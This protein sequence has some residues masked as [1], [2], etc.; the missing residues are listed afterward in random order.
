MKKLLFILGLFISYLGNAQGVVKNYPNTSGSIDITPSALTT[1]GCL[2]AA[3]DTL[4]IPNGTFTC[5]GGDGLQ[6]TSSSYIVIKASANTIFHIVGFRFDNVL[7]NTKYIKFLGGTL[8]TC[9]NSQ[10]VAIQHGCRNLT[11]ESM[12]F[13]KHT[14]AQRLFQFYENTSSLNWNGNRNSVLDSMKFHKCTFNGEENGQFINA[15]NIDNA[16]PALNSICLDWEIDSCTFKNLISTGGAPSCIEAKGAWG[17]KI[18]DNIFDSL[19]FKAP[20]NTSIHL[21]FGSIYGDHNDI[22][23]NRFSH[24]RANAIRTF[25]ITFNALNYNSGTVANRA[26]KLYNNIRSTT[27]NYPMFEVNPNNQSS[28]ISGSAGVLTYGPTQIYFNTDYSSTK[29]IYTGRLVDL[30]NLIDSVTIAHNV[31]ILP[32]R[33]TTY[34]PSTNANYLITA[35]GRNAIDTFNNKVFPTLV[36]AGVVDTL[37]FL[38]L[39]SSLLTD[40]ATTTAPVVGFDIYNISRPQGSARDIGS[41]ERTN[42]SNVPPVANAGPNQTINLPTTTATLDGSG[43]TDP[44]GTITTYSWVKTSGPS[45]GTITTPS[46]AISTVTGMVV[47]TYVFTLTV[48]DNNSATN[49]ASTTII[50]NNPPTCVLNS[51]TDTLVVLNTT[52]VTLTSAGSTDSDGTIA[53]YAWSKLSGSGSAISTPTASST[54]ITGLTL[55]IFKYQLIITDNRGATCTSS[56]RI[57]V[58]PN[59]TFYFNERGTLVYDS[60][61]ILRVAYLVKVARNTKSQVL[62]YVNYNNETII[63]PT[64]IYTEFTKTNK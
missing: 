41:V 5:Y 42:A 61:G 46:A 21:Q 20:I 18:H 64:G 34:S 37:A 54:L 38:P 11:W 36:A 30:V 55:G 19:N 15:G 40:A 48:T 56:I 26:N 53:S 4:L 13:L 50:I 16:L 47:G 60:S 27:N 25:P 23:N 7:T 58:L 17:W 45:S 9:G 57:T 52:S 31:N 51:T 1:L 49:S 59:G 14:G 6:G 8:D 22:Y 62:T 2:P 29:E 3:G 12:T 10:F 63:N 24:A 28:W 35:S 43:S 44:D 33:G 32:E 39:A